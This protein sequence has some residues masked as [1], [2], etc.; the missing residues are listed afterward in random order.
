MGSRFNGSHLRRGLRVSDASGRWVRVSDAR[1]ARRGVVRQSRLARVAFGSW[2]GRREHAGRLEPRRVS[3][4]EAQVKYLF[5]RLPATGYRLPAT[6]YRYPLPAAWS[7]KYVPQHQ[8][9]RQ[10]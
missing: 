10:L 6:G 8:D 9:A 3:G 4:D 5:Y 2:I 1:P 7:L